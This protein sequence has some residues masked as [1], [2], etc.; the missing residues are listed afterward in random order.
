MGLTAAVNKELGAQRRSG[1]E[2]LYRRP[3]WKV[4]MDPFFLRVCILLNIEV[5]CCGGGEYPPNRGRLT[6][7][8]ISPHQHRLHPLHRSGHRSRQGG[9]ATPVPSLP[10][11]R[12]TRRSR[13]ALQLVLPAQPHRGLD[14]LGRCTALA[15]LP[16][17][18]FGAR[19]WR[20]LALA[21]QGGHVELGQ[22]G[23]NTQ[24]LHPG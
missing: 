10:A 1:G 16:S 17:K 8:A 15:G 5:S 20:N 7:P 13:L 22:Q 19:R 23:M 6:P 2:T 12:C 11:A 3:A 24:L 4:T 9:E 18:A 14:V 21:D